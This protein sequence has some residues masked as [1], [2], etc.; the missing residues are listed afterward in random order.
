[1]ESSRR[2]LRTD[3]LDLQ[4]VHAYSLVER[5]VDRDLAPMARALGLGVAA[6]TP[7]ASGWLTGKYRHDRQAAGRLADPVM[8][9]FLPRTDRNVRIADEVCAVAEEIGCAP[10]HVAL[11]WLRRRGAVPVFGATAPEQIRE[12]AACF[13][14]GLSDEQADRLTDVSRIKLGYPHDF[15]R[16]GLVRRLMHGKNADLIDVPAHPL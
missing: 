14:F 13:E 10:A 1:M 7:L 15:L 6:W 11:N 9:R 2:R 3:Y 12:N 4:W 8:S 5:D 16:S